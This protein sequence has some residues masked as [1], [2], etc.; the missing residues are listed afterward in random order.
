MEHLL[1][2]KEKSHLV[3]FITTTV[4]RLT[5]P[6]TTLLLPINTPTDRHQLMLKQ[7][8]KTFIIN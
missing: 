4:H 1:C 8:T 3:G 6:L 7:K 5:D 2:H